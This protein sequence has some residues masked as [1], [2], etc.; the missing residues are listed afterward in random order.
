MLLLMHWLNSLWWRCVRFGFRLLYNELA[1][2]YDWVSKFVSLGEWRCWQRAVLDYL[3]KD[4]FVLE[5]AHGTGDLQL[6][7][8]LAGW[9]SIGFDLSKSMGYIASRKLKRYGITPVLVQGR[10]QQLPFKANGFDV[11][12]CTF[13]TPFIMQPETLQEA[14]RVLKS[15]GVLIVV[16]NGRFTN[17]GILQT[18]L[19][20][21]YYITGQRQSNNITH[22]QDR[23]V[24]YFQQ[25]GFD[26]KWQQKSCKK[27][28]ADLIFAQKL[29]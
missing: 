9:R 13:P 21:L 26:A 12:V 19:T 20:W 10:A 4:A 2:T 25:Y 17:N 5:L 11:I 23:V 24:T 3:P 29:V 18:F 15:D 14:W 16:T 28:V 7:L 6:D 22:V 27:S 1:F 8:N